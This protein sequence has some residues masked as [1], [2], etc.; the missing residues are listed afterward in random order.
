[1]PDTN[2]LLL[3]TSGCIVLGCAPEWDLFIEMT[4]VD[5]V[6][7][8]VVKLSLQK[9]S[10]AAVYHLSNPTM[11]DWDNYIRQYIVDDYDVE[12]LPFFE[13]QKNYL[14]KIDEKNPLFPLKI[15]YSGSS[16]NIVNKYATTNTQKQ[17]NI[18][19]VNYPQ[20]Y[21]QLM[22]VYCQYLDKIGFFFRRQLNDKFGT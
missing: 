21:I 18:L 10:N 2:H 8:A 3:L 16:V 14:N 7:L 5:I 1:M 13:W 6:S 15:I 17:L 9:F 20:D 12:L 19:G 4:P 11:I 22:K